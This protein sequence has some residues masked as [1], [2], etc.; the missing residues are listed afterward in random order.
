MRN[1]RYLFFFI[2]AITLISLFITAT[3][4]LPGFP[5]FDINVRFGSF[6]FAR[7][8][9]FRLGLDLVGGTN[10]TLKA[11]MG[12]INAQDRTAALESAKNVIEKRVNLFG[13]SEPVVQ[14]AKSND[15][16]RIIVELPGVKDV[17]QAVALIGKTAQLEFE[18]R[19]SASESAEL[20]LKTGVS[21]KDLQRAYVSFDPN[22][23][24]PEISFELTKDGSKKFADLTRKILQKKEGERQLAIVLDDQIVSAPVV[25]SVIED[26]GRI[27]G[28]F[29]QDQAKA[30][31]VQLNA[32]ALPVSMTPIEQHTIGA[33]LGEESIR[34]SL[35]AGLV[36]FLII[37][38][39]MVSLYSW[40]GLLADGALIVYA[41]I[42][43]AIFKLFPITL[44]LSGIAGFILSV[45]MA[46][47]ANILI[48]ERMREERRV[49][50][51][52]TIALELG[53]IRAWTSIRDSNIASL[54]TC[55]IL[56]QFGTGIVRGFA[57]TLALGIL[58][59]MFSAIIITRTFLRLVFRH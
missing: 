33:T 39:F 53:F 5:S 55:A 9:S 20:F 14:T 25:Q 56:Y 31:V 19:N 42:V 6:S 52:R 27:T 59:S 48:F 4:T 44:T 29:T 34:K 23:G 49:G 10:V 15:E 21:G 11:D 13:V 22:T 17:N 36:G 28:D 46:V 35:L 40:L 30:L 45:G 16:Y 41:L 51:P 24:K 7:D 47:D 37:V 43:L 3:N 8:L 18:E 1:P 12:S 50:K 26:R 32:G 38:I 54:I 58:V 2:V 57:I